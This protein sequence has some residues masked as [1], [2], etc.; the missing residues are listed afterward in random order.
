MAKKRARTISEDRAISQTVDRLRMEGLEET[1]AVAAAFR[2]YR[3]GELD[4]L[5]SR[6]QEI[7]QKSEQ[8]VEIERDM[9]RQ[10]AE[11]IRRERR[12]RRLLQAALAGLIAQVTK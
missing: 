11:R 8:E 6:Q 2:M 9:I 5:I 4:R 10:M 12:K 3:D 1:R 7:P